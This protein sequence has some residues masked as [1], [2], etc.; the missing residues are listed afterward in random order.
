MMNGSWKA[1]A[2]IAAL[3]GA[4]RYSWSEVVTSGFLPPW[5]VGGRK[6][7]PIVKLN[8]FASA[9]STW[10][11]PVRELTRISLSANGSPA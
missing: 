3:V 1:S 6:V 5:W 10:R 9:E 11:L 8:C 2:V 4:Q 7:A